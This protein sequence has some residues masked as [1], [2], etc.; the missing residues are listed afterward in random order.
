M[1]VFRSF[2]SK[3]LARVPGPSDIHTARISPVCRELERPG[4]QIVQLQ[5]SPASADS[6]DMP[7][8]AHHRVTA[9]EQRNF[10]HARVFWFVQNLTEPLNPVS[11]MIYSTT[12]P[13]IELDGAV[14]VL[15]APMSSPRTSIGDTHPAYSVDY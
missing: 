5:G 10:A 4:L 3:R 8:T 13:L 6:V 9:A 11:C 2:I 14:E 15:P 12:G 7:V 1:L